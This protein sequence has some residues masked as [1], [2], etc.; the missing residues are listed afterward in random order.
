[1]PQLNVPFSISHLSLAEKVFRLEFEDAGSGLVHA[2]LFIFVAR[3]SAKHQ[4]HVGL[5]ACTKSSY[6]ALSQV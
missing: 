5:S 4:M 1:M 3:K 2:T 6:S